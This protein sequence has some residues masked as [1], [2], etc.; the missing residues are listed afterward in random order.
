MNSKDLRTP[1]FILDAT[2]LRKLYRGFRD[3]LKAHFAASEVAYSVKTNSNPALLRVL[4]EEEQRR[5]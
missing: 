2:E 5:R 4:L 3:A 1:C